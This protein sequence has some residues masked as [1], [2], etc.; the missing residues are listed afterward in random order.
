M[1]NLKV[2]R[3]NVFDY[4]IAGINQSEGGDASLITFQQ[5]EFILQNGG[6][7]KIAANN[8]SGVGSYTFTVKQDGTV[9]F[10][11]GFMDDKFDEQKVTLP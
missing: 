5:P 2:N 9:E 1:S 6:M 8:K 7:W 10:W 11:D 4:V 3:D